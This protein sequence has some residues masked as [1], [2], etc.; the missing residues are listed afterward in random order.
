MIKFVIYPSVILVLFLFQIEYDTAVL[1]IDVSSN[2]Y[3][4]S[5]SNQ[6]RAQ[7]NALRIF[8]LEVDELYEAEWTENSV[9]LRA[10]IEVID[11][12]QTCRLLKDHWR[13][14]NYGNVVRGIPLAHYI[15]CHQGNIKWKMLRL[16]ADFLD[17]KTHLKN[18]TSWPL[19][20][21]A[22]FRLESEYNKYRVQGET[23]KYPWWSVFLL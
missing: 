22:V 2:Y 4:Q 9:G 6:T 21:W 1:R 8:D 14:T 17:W 16:P 19:S 7:R 11:A 10:E 5:W 18:I 3:N 15:V 23:N 12:H 13:S 20:Y